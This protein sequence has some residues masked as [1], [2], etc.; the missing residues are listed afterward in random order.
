[1]TFTVNLLITGVSEREIARRLGEIL[2]VWFPE[3]KIVPINI[4][5]VPEPDDPKG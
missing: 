4:L 1:M 2:P 3:M 5:P